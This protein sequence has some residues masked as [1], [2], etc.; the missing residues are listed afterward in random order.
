MSDISLFDFK[1][2][3]IEYCTRDVK[4]TLLFIKILKKMLK[5]LNININNTYS[6][7]S[8][9]LKI[10]IKKFNNDKLAFRHNFLLDKF[11]RSAYYGGV[12]LVYGNPR[13]NEKIF[14]YDFSGM[15]GQ[16]MREKFVFGDYKINANPTEINKPGYY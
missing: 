16:C 4:I 2:Y 3:T 8:L 6:A 13:K 7:P 11:T 5:D 15:Y 1:K 12:C 14:H 10:F 9:S